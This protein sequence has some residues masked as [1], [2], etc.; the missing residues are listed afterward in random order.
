MAPL[1]PSDCS[2]SPRRTGYEKRGLSQSWLR[3][4][5]R[6]VGVSIPDPPPID[7]FTA[8]AVRNLSQSSVRH[9]DDRLFTIRLKKEAEHAWKCVCDQ[10]RHSAYSHPYKEG[11]I[12]GFIDY[13]DAG[14]GEPPFVPP[15]R[16]RLS[17]HRTE[18]GLQM[19]EDWYA[20]FR[21]G[22]A[23]ARESGLRELSLVPMP[24]PVTKPPQTVPQA[25]IPIEAPSPYTPSVPLPAPRPIEPV[26]YRV[27]IPLETT[28]A[29]RNDSGVPTA[30]AP[31]PTTPN[32]KWVNFTA[33]RSAVPGPAASSATKRT[34]R[35]SLLPYKAPASE[36]ERPVPCRASTTPVW[37]LVPNLLTGWD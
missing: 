22:A 17:K 5:C 28:K 16:F 21:H 9:V 6:A 8:I 35:A 31:I 7:T 24:G 25:N 32:L 36:T 4:A 11:F 14:E 10:P 37:N 20:G 33:S 3:H 23:V 1:W 26:S 12:E 18:D 34:K 30:P 2:P 15:L 27:A 19:I 29:S 13:V